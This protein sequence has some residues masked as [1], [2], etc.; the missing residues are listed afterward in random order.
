MRGHGAS[1]LTDKVRPS[2]ILV[3]R[4][5]EADGEYAAPFVAVRSGGTI[6]LCTLAS[7]VLEPRLLRW[8]ETCSVGSRPRK[9]ATVPWA[10][11][12]QRRRAISRRRGPAVSIY[13]VQM[14]ATRGSHRKSE[15][16]QIFWLL[17]IIVS[18]LAA[19]ARI[20]YLR[21]RRWG[22]GMKRFGIAA[23]AT[24]V[25]LSLALAQPRDAA[26][27]QPNFRAWRHATRSNLIET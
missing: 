24:V 20:K 19:A 14:R 16:S 25:F 7:A 8:Q 13:G 3:S 4:T 27:G 2:L 12:A 9:P 11:I 23:A 18:I 17:V 15:L 6:A 1:L 10:G 5:S 26:R 22:W 21:S